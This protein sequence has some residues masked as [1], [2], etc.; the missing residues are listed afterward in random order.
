MTA[1]L[2]DDNLKVDNLPT[3]CEKLG[4]PVLIHI[5]PTFDGYYGIV[6]E[7]HLPCLEKMLQKY[8]D[9]KIS[10]HSQLFWSEISADVT[11]ETRV[12]YPEGKVTDGR[13]AELLRK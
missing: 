9:L 5:A 2:Y 4:L 8:P 10:G 6:D 13:V 1:N 7:I 3:H 11:D 12:G